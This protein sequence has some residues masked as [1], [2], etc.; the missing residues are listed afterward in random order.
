MSRRNQCPPQP[1]DLL[2]AAAARLDD[3][4]GERLAQAVRADIDW[5]KLAR[6][7]TRH[8]VMPLLCRRLKEL[9]DPRIPRAWLAGLWR[10]YLRNEAVL[11]QRVRALL[12]LLRQL[13]HSGVPIVVFKGPF[14]AQLYG[15]PGMRQYA[16]LDLLVRPHDF[17][18]TVAAARDH[19]M[20]PAFEP[21]PRQ[22]R[23]L[24]KYHGELP[25]RGG[26]G[27]IDLDL[28]CRLVEHA[29]SPGFANHDWLS[30]S[31]PFDL[32]G[33]TVASLGPAENLLVSCF[34]GV[35]HGWPMIASAVD[36]AMVLRGEGDTLDWDTVAALATRTG[37]QGF[38][39]Q[40]LAVAHEMT[41]VAIPPGAQGSR[42]AAR[43]TADRLRRQVGT[44]LTMLRT[45]SGLLGGL[46]SMGSRLHYILE[47]LFRP[48]ENDWLS[49]RLPDRFYF[50]YF[51]VRPF[52]LVATRL[53]V[54]R[55]R[56][57]PARGRGHAVRK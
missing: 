47:R 56:L 26:K 14:L 4:G 2:L 10:G 44:D 32:E 37:M 16:D 1:H 57:R 50:L 8:R 41:G 31:R 29:V 25:F 15:G 38:L 7:A 52:R 54:D 55:A 46:S 51:I 42:R 24:V 27:E 48:A 34:H 13:A 28:H 19:G 35:K 30:T 40:G 3:P 17:E 23:E 12:P 43:R 36:V 33:C 5:E 49:L 21:T 53:L 45:A 20:R 22:M 6:A 9:G 18:R 39:R 11:V